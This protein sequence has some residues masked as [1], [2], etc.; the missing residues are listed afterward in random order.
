M[1][2]QPPRE[3]FPWLR[4]SRKCALRNGLLVVPKSRWRNATSCC[5]SYL[6]HSWLKSLSNLW[7][8]TWTGQR[9][10]ALCPWSIILAERWASEASSS[11]SPLRAQRSKNLIVS[12]LSLPWADHIYWLLLIDFL[13]VNQRAS[14]RVKGPIK[15]LQGSSLCNRLLLDG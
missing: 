13:L 10:G 5:G 6:P 15:T 4:K 14:C 9:F 7:G 2:G 8:L 11:D 3:D 12:W 1:A